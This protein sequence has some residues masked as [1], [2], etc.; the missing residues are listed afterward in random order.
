MMKHILI[1]LVLVGSTVGCTAV[2]IEPL[3]LNPLPPEAKI[4]LSDAKKTELQKL[5]MSYNRAKQEILLDCSERAS[6]L[7]RIVKNRDAGV[8]KE[9]VNGIVFEVAQEGID[10]NKP[11]LIGNV[12]Y[13]IMLTTMIY[14]RKE[15]TPIDAFNAEFTGCTK[16]YF[17]YLDM[18]VE[19]QKERIMNREEGT[20]YEW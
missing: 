9:A 17:R 11:I 18:A 15:I 7:E 10:K 3:S 2:A 6:H 8:P 20:K 1:L 13:Q 16:F 4:L 5:E 12:L 19:R 14:N